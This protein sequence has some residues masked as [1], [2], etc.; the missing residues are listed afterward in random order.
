ME[1]SCDVKTRYVCLC[2]GME[3]VFCITG[4][5]ECP[6]PPD[7]TSRY[8]S[9]TVSDGHWSGWTL[10]CPGCLLGCSCRGTD[11]TVVEERDK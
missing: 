1:V 8:L 11:I 10:V 4:G 7:A 6:P 3:S 2:C 9:V 5:G